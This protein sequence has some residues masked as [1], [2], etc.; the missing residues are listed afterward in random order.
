MLIAVRPNLI[1]VLVL[2][3][4]EKKG[5]RNGNKTFLYSF[6]REVQYNW[7]FA[8]W[9]KTDGARFYIRTRKLFIKLIIAEV[10]IL[11]IATHTILQTKFM[12][13]RYAY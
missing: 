5:N 2:A 13:L 11:L 4:F 3:K 12:E 8:D 9:V 10:Q 7:P 1:F 6:L